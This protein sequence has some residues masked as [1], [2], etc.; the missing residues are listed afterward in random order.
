MLKRLLQPKRDE[1]LDQFVERYLLNCHSG[2]DTFNFATK[3]HFSALFDHTITQDRDAIVQTTQKIAD[4]NLQARI[5][6]IVLTNE[7]SYFKNTLSNILVENGAKEDIYQLFVL[8]QNVENIIATA[9]LNQYIQSLLTSNR[10]RINSLKDM[11]EKRFLLYYQHHLEWLNALA[12]TIQNRDT[13]LTPELN[14]TLCEFGKWLINDAKTI[15]KNN[16]K[17][18]EIVFQHQLLHDLGGMLNKQLDKEKHDDNVIMSYLEKCEMISLAIG[19]ELALIDNSYMIQKAAKDE[20]T[21]AL[22]RNSLKPIFESQYELSLAT[23]TTF[24]LAMC[25]LDHFKLVNDTYGHIAGDRLLKEFVSIIKETLRDSDIVVRYG[26]EEFI[27][28]LPNSNL[29]NAKKRLE[30]IRIKFQ[31]SKCTYKEKSLSTTVSIG[32]TQITPKPEEYS[33]NLNCEPFIA[34]ADEKLYQSKSNGRNRTSC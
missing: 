25:D 9:Y 18:K 23:D 26:G 1:I 19:T 6:Y 12:I 31:N 32:M 20:L 27:I 24:V 7:I 13:S 22:N 3:E 28:L 34:Q 8:Y 29:D 5:P 33:K 15:I 11:I 16:S 21:G 4:Y 2:S 17:Y 30:E 10:F 14:P